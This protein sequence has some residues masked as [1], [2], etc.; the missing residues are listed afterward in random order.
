MSDASN[1]SS[2]SAAADAVRRH[3]AA[4]AEA[5]S[6]RTEALVAAASAADATAAESARRELV[7]WCVHELVPHARAEE[8]TM[9]P[10]GQQ[11]VEGRLLVTA[12]RD[13]HVVI[14]G[15]VEGLS[16]ASDPVRAAA[17]ALALYTMFRSHLGK[18]N[19]LLLPLLVAAPDVSV[20]EL[21][22]GMHE[23]LGADDEES[24]DHSHG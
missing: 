10:A 16:S 21:L 14:T 13:E 7:R 2:D 18:E 15:L 4:M 24:A 9:Y 11:T 20:A 8:Q 23:L 12:M 1:A 22:G 5:V 3:H 17:T 6:R 19:D